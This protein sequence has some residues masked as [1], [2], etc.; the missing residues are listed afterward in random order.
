MYYEYSFTTCVTRENMDNSMYAY[1]ITVNMI[2]S[3]H[4]IK[5]HHVNTI[6]VIHSCNESEFLLSHNKCTILNFLLEHKQATLEI[7]VH[8]GLIQHNGIHNSEC[9]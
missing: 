9:K 4:M 2:Q 8:E 1:H 6:S 3:E 5:Y 7:A